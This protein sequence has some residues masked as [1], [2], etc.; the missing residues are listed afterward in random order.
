MQDDQVVFPAKDEASQLYG[1]EFAAR[2]SHGLTYSQRDAV[3]N[4]LASIRALQVC[5]H[6]TYI[7]IECCKPQLCTS[8]CQLNSVLLLCKHAMY[9]ATGTC[10]CTNLLSMSLSC[11]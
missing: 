10:W 8:A 7:V 6:T 1:R 2:D 3:V 5:A 4:V 9:S 11:T